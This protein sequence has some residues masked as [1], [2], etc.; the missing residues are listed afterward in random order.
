VLF[1]H[2]LQLFGAQLALGSSFDLAQHWL[3][4]SNPLLAINEEGHSGVG[5]FIVLSGFIL[6][7]RAIGNTV[8][9]KPFL[10]ARILRIYPMLVICL[11]VVR[12]SVR[13]TSQAF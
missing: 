5:L 6:S 4:P 10:I 13:A 12:M 11:L 7:L 9:Y 1:Y 2:G 3:R 8:N